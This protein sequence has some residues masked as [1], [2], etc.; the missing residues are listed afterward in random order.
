MLGE[1][2][3]RA[4]EAVD[5]LIEGEF[6]LS[7]YRGETISGAL[8]DELRTPS[9]F[10]KPRVV[11]VSDPKD[12]FEGDTLAALAAYAAAP[13][14]NS[15]LVLQVKGLD[16]RLK[17]AKALKAAATVI[18]CKPLPDGQVPSWIGQRARENYGLYVP[19]AAARVLR[20]RIGEDLGLL[21]GAL[22]RLRD[23]IA[24]RTE[25]LPSDVEESTE[26]HRSPVMW[27]A[28]NA[29]QAGD[30]PAALAAIAGG[31]LDGI[32]IRQDVVT[33]P[34]AVA[35]ILLGNLHGA[36]KNLLRY[37]MTGGD[38]KALGL[39]PGAA[40]HLS[41]KAGRHRFDSLVRRHR[42]FVDADL[43]LK[44]SLDEPRRIIEH[45]LVGLL[46]DDTSN[47]SSA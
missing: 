17:A 30:L 4:R 32:R 20:E 39:P 35:P 19:P 23:Q 38:E 43:A 11:L 28:A 41:Q 7:R 47:A 33:D 13:A 24:P 31:F 14:P 40:Y 36:Y 44:R 27:E 15:L 25:V 5:R 26:E 45:L 2:R 16:G 9:L 21:D 1:D 6:D 37:H 8:F 42:L 22:E 34:K 46:V 12:L 18:E 3:F 29:L 10:G